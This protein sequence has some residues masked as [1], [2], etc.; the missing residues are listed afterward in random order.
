MK[1]ASEEDAINLLRRIRAGADPEAVVKH[2]KDGNLLM[3]LSLAPEYRKRYD[4]PYRT[5]IPA[6]LLTPDNLYICPTILKGRQEPGQ[7]L[8]YTRPYHAATLSDA[9]IDEITVSKWTTI[10]LSEKLLRQL[11]R[12]FFQF[13]YAEW[14]PFHKG[15]FLSDMA[16]DRT[17][18]CSSLLVNAVLANACYSSSKL[19]ERAKY[20]LPENLTYKFTAEA[21]RLW[22]IEIASGRKRLTTVQASQI[23]SVIMDFDGIKSLGRVYTDHGLKMARDLSLFQTP[24]A[25]T[26][27]NMRKACV[28]TAWSLFSWHS[29]I[30]Y[31]FHTYPSITEPPE[32]PLPEDPSWYGDIYVQYPPSEA[33]I[34]THVGHSFRAKCRLRSIKNAIAVHAFGLG[35]DTND[36]WLTLTEADLYCCQLEAWR[37]SLPEQ[38][39]PSRVVFPKD[40]GTQ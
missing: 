40:I 14:F 18:F 7:G 23:L 16:A 6:Y 10:L 3:Q 28:W 32:D 4:L 38:L 19:P 22:Q 35:K 29:M 27:H 25:G 5:E 1:E 37:Q 24:F 26:S 13:A 15:L 11:L 36:T 39:Q 31:Y 2:V 33:L 12:S 17:E 9:L 21:K 8:S 20:W 34:S 30:S